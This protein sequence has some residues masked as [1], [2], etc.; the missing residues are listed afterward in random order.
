MRGLIIII[1]G[2]M[3]MLS[4]VHPMKNSGDDSQLV[5]VTLTEVPVL[6]AISLYQRVGNGPYFTDDSVPKTE[7]EAILVSVDVRN[8]TGA[9]YFRRLGKAA[10]LNIGIMNDGRIKVTQLSK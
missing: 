1:I 8:V 9:E 5:S 7:L 6:Q 4:C 10:G 3:L 2:S